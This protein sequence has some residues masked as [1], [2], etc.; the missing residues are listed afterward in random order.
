MIIASSNLGMKSQR[1]YEVY[2][3]TKLSM[4]DEHKEKQDELINEQESTCSYEGEEKKSEERRTI[5]NQKRISTGKSFQVKTIHRIAQPDLKEEIKNLESIRQ[6]C[7]VY[8]WACLFGESR[9]KQLADE[10]GMTLPSSMQSGSIL[11]H[12]IIED[13]GKEGDETADVIGDVHKE[14]SEA[15]MAEGQP[16][17]TI[18]SPVGTMVLV[19]GERG[20]GLTAVRETCYQEEETTTFSTT[21]TVK[22]AD[23][24]ELSFRLNLNMSRTFTK[25]T[26]ETANS[27]ASFIDPLVINLNGN[28]SQVT[29]Q[30]FF[31]DLDADGKEERIARL[32]KDSGYLALDLNED[33]KINDGKEMFG[34]TSGNGFNDLAKYDQDGNG[35]IDERDQVWNRLKIWVQR[36]DGSDQLLSLKESGVGALCLGYADTNFI[37]RDSAGQVSAAI[38]NTGIFLYENG[39]AGTLQHLDLAQHSLLA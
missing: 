33:G 35:W 3:F 34:T 14:N 16:Q 20:K 13:K 25:Y 28:I 17:I 24:R 10:Y 15:Y 38:R 22:T 2:S 29:D 21:G 5:T 23:G 39:M 4:K 9:A 6:Q 36:E 18:L 32:S 26:R 31:F 1:Y 30:Q 27:M 37:Q 12:Q 11:N 19:K 8:L 7:I